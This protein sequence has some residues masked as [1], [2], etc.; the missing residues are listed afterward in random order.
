MK[1]PL[2]KSQ[3]G[4][5]LVELLVLLIVVSIMIAVAMQTMT[6][7]MTDYRRVKT[8]REMATLATA[9]VGDPE[10]AA[11]G[12]RS[13]F[14]YVGD[15]GAFP[16]N[17]NALRTNPGYGTWNGPYLPS[18]MAADS[19]GFKTDEWGKVYAYSGGTVIQSTGSGSTLKHEIARSTNDYLINRLTG[20][21][22]DSA[23]I[24]PGTESDSISV[25]VTIPNGSGSLTSKIYHPNSSGQ[26]TLD[27]LPVGQ[28]SLEIIYTPANDTLHRFV[29]ILPR[30]RSTTHYKFASA[31]FDTTATPPADTSGMEILRP[32]GSGSTTELSDENCSQN[33]SCVDEVSSDGDG[34]YVKGSGSQW[35]YDLYQAEDHSLGSGTIDSVIIYIYAKGSGGGIKA[36]SYLR[37][38]G[39]NYDGNEYLTTSSYVIYSDTYVDNPATGN[40]WTWTEIDNLQIGC[41]AKKEAFITQV[42]VEVYYTP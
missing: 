37:T 34:S 35:D 15:L 13:D 12:S 41:G 28:H 4:F 16:P 5:G 24:A 7:T 6:A 20:T 42:W 25:M 8:E 36:K 22:V 40:P 31:W 14:G 39:S 3:H 10:K 1:S 26:F 19:L 32:N 21:I 29:Q 38:N 2:V 17:L 23:G 30:H 11:D 18:D 9:I 33:W 27:S